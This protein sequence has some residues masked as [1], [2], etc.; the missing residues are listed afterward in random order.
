MIIKGSVLSIDTIL[1]PATAAIITISN[2]H[3]SPC[4]FNF[5]SSTLD[6]HQLVAQVEFSNFDGHMKILDR[7]TLNP[8]VFGGR[9]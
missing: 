7:I 8:D 1:P 3:P 9:A 2:P 5:I 4:R 6:F